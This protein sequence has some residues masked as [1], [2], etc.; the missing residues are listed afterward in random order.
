MPFVVKAKP[1]KDGL[2][3]KGEGAHAMVPFHLNVVPLRQ[4][5]SPPA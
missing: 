2:T 4:N 5:F 3:W 1:G